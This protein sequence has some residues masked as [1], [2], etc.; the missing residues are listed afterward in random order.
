M[1]NKNPFF[2]LKICIDFFKIFEKEKRKKH[3]PCNLE[4]DEND[5]KL[6]C[7]LDKFDKSFWEDFKRF[8][9]IEKNQK[10]FFWEKNLPF[11]DFENLFEIFE[12]RKIN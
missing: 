12:K 10:R 8:E 1:K 6:I 9:K 4:K 3:N 7:F 11:G 5:R 2:P